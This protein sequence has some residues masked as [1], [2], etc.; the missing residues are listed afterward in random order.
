MSDM[1]FA[2][3]CV[4]RAM[5]FK[6]HSTLA[7]LLGVMA[8]VFPAAGN[9]AKA[10]SKV[11]L[12][13]FYGG[14]D[15]GD[16][17]GPL[18]ADQAGNLYGTTE[19]GGGANL[20]VVYELSPRDGGTWTETV[21]HSFNGADGAYANP[22][23]T[24][25][26]QGNLY[27]TTFSGTGN[28]GGGVVF[29]LSPS[30]NG[31]WTYTLLN[32][33]GNAGSSEGSNPNGNLVLD[34][35][36]NLFGSTQ[37]GGAGVCTNFP[38]PCGVV[39]KL[40]PAPGKGGKWSETVI[41]SFRG[42]PDGSFPYGSVIFDTL[43]NLYGTTNEG[44]TG[45][46]ND[47]EGTIIGCGTVFE[48]TASQSWAESRLYNFKKSEQNGPGDPLVFGRNGALYGTAGYDVFRLKPVG[49]IWKKQTIYEFTE[50]IAGTIP[51]SGVTFDRHGNLYGTTSS[52]GLDGYST[53]FELSPLK[54][55][56]G[57]WTQV[58]LAKFGKGL[59][60]NQPRGG[61]LV[62][63]HGTLYGAVSDTANRGYDFAI[64]R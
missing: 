64:A 42:P 15:G 55:G 24:P 6:G 34:A 21:L 62:G 61:V 31:A 32:G 46:C 14:N 25:D 26:S 50:G 27:G 36:G 47:G 4:R 8:L 19:F 12:H 20:G 58:T 17:Y 11:V 30:G 10:H 35:S 40:S 60:S 2:G 13:R 56:G 22:G 45:K 9:F 28:V 3:N 51:F 44:G 57:P 29:E 5:R 39:F 23:L 54:A 7:A 18:I 49:K 41:Y 16:P 1:M 38:G 48:L 59:D 37:L 53:V 33:F 63:Q 43:G 52:S